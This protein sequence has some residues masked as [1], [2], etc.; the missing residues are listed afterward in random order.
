MKGNR[1]IPSNDLGRRMQVCLSPILK[2][3][4][5]IVYG[6]RT[7]GFMIDL[8]S[9]ADL[10]VHSLP[11][12]PNL[13]NHPTYVHLRPPLHLVDQRFVTDRANVSRHPLNLYAGTLP[14]YP[15]EGNGGGEGDTGKG[16]KILYVQ[17]P[18]CPSCDMVC[19]CAF[20]YGEDGEWRDIDE[21]H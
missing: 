17:I 5:G 19:A 20:A 1:R 18:S 2:Y 21:V 11:G 9:A 8:P 14:S 10:Y 15:G 13:A 4:S 3:S 16:S 7:D 6:L 12:V